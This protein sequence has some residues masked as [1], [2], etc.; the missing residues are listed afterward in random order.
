MRRTTVDLQD[1][2]IELWALQ[3]ARR[4]C[5]TVDV[6]RVCGMRQLMVRPD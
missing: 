6:E 3:Q 2:P 1:S 5:N 4:I